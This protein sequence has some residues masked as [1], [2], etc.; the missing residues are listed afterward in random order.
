M[1]SQLETGAWVTRERIKGYSILLI[2]AYAL[3][4]TAVFLTLKGHLDWQDRPFGSDFGGLYTAGVMAAEGTPAAPYGL[5]VFE[6]RQQALFGPQT[7]V[8]SWGYPPF[9]LAVFR[10]L[11]GLPYLSALFLWQGI[12]LA[13]YLVMLRGWL[14]PPLAL[15]GGAAFTGVFVTLGHGQ[16]GFLIAAL[17]GAALLALERR[18]LLAG[19]L[20]GLVAIK[21]HFGLLIP[22]ALMAGGRWR[23][24]AAASLM[25]AA[26]TAA[27]LAAFGAETFAAFLDS[28]AVSRVHGVEQSNT[29]FHKMQSA[30]TAVRLLGG[31]VGLAYALHGL[32][33][34]MVVATTLWIWR[35]P[36]DPR[37][38]A[39]SLMTGAF[40]AT[41]YVFDYDMVLLAPAMAALVDYGIERG[42]R[43]FE[44]SFLALAFAMPILARSIAMAAP[45]PAGFL[46]CLLLFA[47]I[48]A[49]ARHNAGSDA[50]ASV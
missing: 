14:K 6:A 43:P 8:F 42:F 12:T 20:F 15:L 19:A 21:P 26:M 33:L 17:F 28:L 1:W 11:A 38:R 29:G 37:L 34:G 48:V 16:M 13:L 25:V 4:L 50:A 49:K 7:A 23:A 10:P 24:F 32:L 27:A 40:L 46:T 47:L 22:V 36:V 31:P 2:V 18:P 45:I 41:P 35:R 39:A 3:G 44:K 30:F 5:E 9:T